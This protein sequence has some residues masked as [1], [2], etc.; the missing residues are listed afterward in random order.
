MKLEIE[1]CFKE[2]KW[3]AWASN[4][5]MANI[6][7][8]LTTLAFFSF[9]SEGRAWVKTSK[10]DK[11]RKI[12]IPFSSIVSSASK[13][14]SWYV[15]KL[16]LKRSRQRT[17]WNNYVILQV[18]LGREPAEQIAYSTN[19]CSTGGENKPD[20]GWLAN[21]WKPSFVSCIAPHNLKNKKGLESYDL[22]KTRFIG[23]YWSDLHTGRQHDSDQ[24]LW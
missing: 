19:T 21:V 6:L 16:W 23:D 1:A 22:L 17:A 14:T 18:K 24:V 9:T 10:A 12:K 3:Y 5:R 2:T 15:R 20:H 11:I 8:K 4:T 13:V 7:N